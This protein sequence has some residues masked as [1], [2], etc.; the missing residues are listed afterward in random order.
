MKAASRMLN[1]NKKRKNNSPTTAYIWLEESSL[2]SSS[3][4]SLTKAAPDDGGVDSSACNLLDPR[5]E[6]R[7]NSFWAAILSSVSLR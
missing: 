5:S 6:V 3:Y 1:K 2:M 7:R 4:A